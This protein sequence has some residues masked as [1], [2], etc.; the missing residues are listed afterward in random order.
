MRFTQVSNSRFN[1]IKVIINKK[2]KAIDNAYIVCNNINILRQH[3]RIVI[4]LSKRDLFAHC[5]G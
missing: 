3:I 5:C 2:I 4:V 1:Q